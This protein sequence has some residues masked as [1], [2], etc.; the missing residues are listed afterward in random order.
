MSTKG[1]NNALV[2]DSMEKENDGMSDKVFKKMILGIL[3][4]IQENTD[5]QLNDVRKTMHDMNEKFS[6][7]VTSNSHMNVLEMNNS[8]NQTKYR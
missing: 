6:K 5:G 3:K 7:E 4:E 8:I 1:H 2:R